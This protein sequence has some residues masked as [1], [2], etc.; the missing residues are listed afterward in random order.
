MEFEEYL[1][2]LYSCEFPKK[3]NMI[4]LLKRRKDFLKQLGCIKEAAQVE[5]LIQYHEKQ[6]QL[7]EEEKKNIIDKIIG[8]SIKPKEYKFNAKYIRE[9][10]EENM[11]KDIK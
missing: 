7:T 9:T 11:K 10:N 1:E 2:L 6:G 5:F 3:E 4:E 8:V